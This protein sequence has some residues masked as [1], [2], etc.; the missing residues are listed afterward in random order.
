MV[1][2]PPQTEQWKQVDLLF[3]EA[4]RHDPAEWRSFLGQRCKGDVALASEIQSLLKNYQLDDSLLEQVKVTDPLAYFGTKPEHLQ[5]GEILGSYQV[6]DFVRSGGMGDIYLARDI[7]LARKVAIKLL[8][9]VLPGDEGPLKRFIAEAQATSALNHPNILTVYDFGQQGDITYIVSEWIEGVQLRE[10]IHALSQH[11]AVTYARQIASALA[12]AHA[13]GIIHRDIKPENIMVRPDG[14]IKVLDFGLA[15]FIRAEEALSD[16]SPARPNTLPGLLLGTPNYMAPEQLRGN[17]ADELSDIWSLG[18]LFYEMLAGYAPFHAGT[19]ADIL[20]N[21]LHHEPLPPCKDRRLNF[22]VQHCLCKDPEARIQKMSEVTEHL[23][24]AIVS[25]ELEVGSAPIAEKIISTASH[26]RIVQ[27]TLWAALVCLLALSGVGLLRLYEG[28]QRKPFHIDRISR[29]TS[30][31]NVVRTALSRDGSF[32]AYAAGDPS[33]QKLHLLQV[34]TQADSERLALHDGSIIGITFAP[35]QKYIFYVVDR[36]GTGTLYR[37]PMLSGSPRVIVS[38]IDSAISFSPQGDHYAFSRLDPE[39]GRDSIIVRKTDGEGE[40]ILA[41]IVAPRYLAFGPVWMPDGKHIVTP[42]YDEANGAAGKMRFLSVDT[43]S[44]RQEFGQPLSWLPTG[45]PAYLDS[46]HLITPGRTSTSSQTNLFSVAWRSGRTELLTHES[47]AYEGIGGG[48]QFGNFVALQHDM[49]SNVWLLSTSS[50]DPIRLSSAGSRL[51]NIAWLDGES[52][53]SQ[54]E[55]NGHASLIR[56]DTHG[57]DPEVIGSDFATDGLPAASAQS[58]YLVS[59]IARDG[60]FHLWRSGKDG[61]NPI[62][63]TD[64]NYLETRPTL[65]PNGKSVVFTS[66]RSNVLSLWRVPIAGGSPTQITTHASTQPTFSP[67]GRF[68]ACLYAENFAA[69]SK[70]TI[71]NAA[72]GAVESI[73]AEIP[74]DSSFRWSRDGNALIAIVTKEGVSNLWSFPL[75]SGQPK[76]LTKFTEGVIH[77]FA[78][79]YENDSV[80]LVRG[81]TMADVVLIQASQ[82]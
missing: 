37:V 20:H 12:A 7:R 19:Q 40:L 54:A 50:A 79:S 46:D 71:L 58:P 36:N 22:L 4:L 16:S 24:R 17:P 69:G 49:V 64:G 25:R 2:N 61:S 43:Q 27:W 59:S 68:I 70:V 39:H 76:Q 23:G 1:Q 15:K 29:L 8:P 65:S 21:I 45:T 53:I 56:I 44:G 3:H 14:L 11:T 32:V 28:T 78:P 63:L 13:L 67:D 6:I 10:N 73:H 60:M 55:L 47:S 33:S 41:T 62:R 72:T 74:E 52:L 75:H 51:R 30:A 31:G 18:V 38:D 42:T 34:T 57:A 5:P 81:S 82:N 80:A 66:S 35:D 77:A 26:N 9:P 48:G